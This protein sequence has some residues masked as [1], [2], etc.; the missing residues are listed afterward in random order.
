MG[1]GTSINVTEEGR[2]HTVP[3]LITC[4]CRN[5]KE[6]M[7]G[8]MRKAGSVASFQ[9]LKECMDPEK[10]ETTEFDKK[11]YYTRVRPELVLGRVFLRAEIK[12]KDGGKFEGLVFWRMPLRDKKHWKRISNIAEPEWRVVKKD[13]FI[14][15]EEPGGTTGNKR[16]IESI[17][18]YQYVMRRVDSR[19]GD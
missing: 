18:M 3:V 8:I 14:G 11:E 1:K 16:E 13:G 19:A 5:I 10:V 7:E 12:M 4:G 9:W 6:R 2:I 15:P 17:N